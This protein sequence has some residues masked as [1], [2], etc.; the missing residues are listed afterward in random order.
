MA[1]V[2]KD[3]ENIAQGRVCRREGFFR[4][5]SRSIGLLPLVVRNLHRRGKLPVPQLNL[6]ARALQIGVP[7]LN[8]LARLNKRGVLSSQILLALQHP[9][10]RHHGQHE[11]ESHDQGCPLPP[12]LL[13][14][15]S[16]PPRRRSLAIKVLPRFLGGAAL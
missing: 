1:R 12:P 9:E 10:D 8:L 3:T 14:A 6:C 7:S 4:V 13:R 5:S 2:L 16:R 11:Q 15:L